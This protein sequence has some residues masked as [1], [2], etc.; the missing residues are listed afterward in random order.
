MRSLEF[1]SARV[2]SIFVHCVYLVYSAL[3]VFLLCCIVIA[4]I[5]TYLDRSLGTDASESGSEV[6]EVVPEDA[7]EV[8]QQQAEV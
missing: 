5:F 7:I 2:R 6:I 4:C 1:S 3:C 8:D